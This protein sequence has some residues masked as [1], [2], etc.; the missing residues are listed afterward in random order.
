[1]G[2]RGKVIFIMLLMGTVGAA[3][4]IVLVDEPLAY[5]ILRTQGIRSALSYVATRETSDDLGYYQSAWIDYRAHNL[6]KAEKKLG[7]LLASKDT[8]VKVGADCHYLLGEIRVLQSQYD[9][10]FREYSQ[11]HGIYL[12]LGRNENLY[13]SSLGL[14][15]ASI[16][17]QDYD[18]AKEY[19]DKSRAYYDVSSR[20]QKLEL[21]LWFEMRAKL[22][23]Y[24]QD[25][26]AAAGFAREGAS[27]FEQNQHSSLAYAYSNL[28]FFLCLDGALREG[29]AYTLL[30]Q[31]KIVA[32]GDRA[33]HVGNMVNF[34]LYYRSTRLP[35]QFMIQQ[36]ED[37][38]RQTGDLEMQHFLDV[39]L[40]HRGSGLPNL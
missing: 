28:G 8:T 18:R 33:A 11:A 3:G 12:S 1:M 37:F 20:K 17:L 40:S 39:A 29:F 32:T 13:L 6:G 23:F 31:E 38:A 35:Y 15:K 16:R 5:S 10:A 9:E 4:A 34:I 36:V 24:Q 14:A 22:A 25:Y 30:A 26:T 21:G 27:L 7:S 2:N 19:L